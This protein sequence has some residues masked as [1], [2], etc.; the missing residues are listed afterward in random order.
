MEKIGGNILTAVEKAPYIEIK[1]VL[2]KA[3]DDKCR[4]NF[5]PIVYQE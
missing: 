5:V 1:I 3:A 2:S 4:I